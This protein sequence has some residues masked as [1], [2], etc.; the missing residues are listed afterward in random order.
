MFLMWPPRYSELFFLSVDHTLSQGRVFEE[1]LNP[2]RMPVK[3]GSRVHLGYI[4]KNKPTQTNTG[5]SQGIATKTVS[6]RGVG[7]AETET[8]DMENHKMYRFS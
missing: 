8:P 7:S 4:M 3:P 1:A 2:E 5:Y 6:S